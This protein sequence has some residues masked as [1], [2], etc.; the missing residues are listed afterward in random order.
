MTKTYTNILGVHISAINYDVCLRLIQSW[1]SLRK[2]KYICVAAVHLVMECQ[3]NPILLAGVNKAGLITPDGMPLIW[4]SKLYGHKHCERVYGPTLMLKLCKLA[5][6]HKW[7]IFLLGGAS[8]QNLLLIKKITQQFPKI[9]I[10]GSKETPTKQLKTK[11]NN[12]I[13]HQINNVKPHI[14]FVG[15]G[16]PYQEL[17]MI[18]NHHRINTNVLIGVGAAFNF[19]SGS[20]KQAPPWAQQSGLEWFYRLY[21]NPRLLWHRYTIINALFVLGIF[22]QLFWYYVASLFSRLQLL[23]KSI[24]FVK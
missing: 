1:I 20:E 18:N 19:L 15:L 4:L 12:K 14:V 22:N 13:L 3:N 9:I 11:E 16:C 21:Q 5:Q 8:R 24:V 17:W 2:K 10:V 23:L 6:F 7:K